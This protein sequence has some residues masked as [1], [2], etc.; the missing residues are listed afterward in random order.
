MIKLSIN[1]KINY[2]NLL[3]ILVKL[4]MVRIKLV[5]TLSFFARYTL[6]NKCLNRLAHRGTGLTPRADRG[7]AGSNPNKIYNISS[8]KK[9]PGFVGSS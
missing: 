9:T 1:K 6:L 3:L 5:L 8:E 2:R 7:V 4:L